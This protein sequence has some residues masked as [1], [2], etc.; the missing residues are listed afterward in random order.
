MD[1]TETVALQVRVRICYED[2]YKEE[3]LQHIKE[4]IEMDYAQGI[5]YDVE[6]VNVL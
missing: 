4:L 1:K 6:V 5:G 3:A 2:G